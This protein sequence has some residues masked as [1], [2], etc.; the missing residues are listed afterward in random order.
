MPHHENA[1]WVNFIDKGAELYCLN[2]DYIDFNGRKA[3][4]FQK[5][6]FFDY[7]H[8]GVKQTLSSKQIIPFFDIAQDPKN[9]F[10]GVSRLKS[11]EDEVHQ[12]WM[13]NK[14]IENQIKLSGNII[15]SPDSHKESELSLGLDK[16]IGATT[17]KTQKHEIEDKLNASGII[18]GKSLTVASTALKA[19]NLAESLKDYDYNEK[20]KQEAGRI[21]MNLY[22]I[23]RKLQNLINSSELQKDKEGEDI[24]LYEKTILPVAGNFAKSINSVYSKLTGTT[25]KL[26]YDH[27]AVFQ[28]RRENA[29]KKE[30]EHKEKTTDLIIKLLDKNLISDQEAIKILKDEKIIA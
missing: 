18:F 9:Q 21:V 15:V 11:L 7:S 13:S 24:D 28:E 17:G 14:A 30:A 4:L 5:D 25:I 10:K 20:F 12:I 8:N 23:P 2:N 6:I 29:K 3:S 27:L 22:E 1:A 26:S 19:I 16:P